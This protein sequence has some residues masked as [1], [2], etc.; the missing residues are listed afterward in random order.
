MD[1]LY[2]SAQKSGPP[3]LDNGLINGTN[4]FDDGGSRLNISFESGKSYRL[5]LV[6]GALDTHFKFMIDNHTMTVIASD[7]VPITPYTTDVISIG[8]GMWTIITN[9]LAWILLISVSLQ[10]NVTMSS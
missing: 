4:T 9:P 5:R 3:T 6:N 7:L 1:E 2:L 10:V 8:M